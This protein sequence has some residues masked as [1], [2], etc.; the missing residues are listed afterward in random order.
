MKLTLLVLCL[1][2]GLADVAG[3]RP[4]RHRGTFP[5]R[6]AV[7]MRYHQSHSQIERWP[8]GSGDLSITTSYALSDGI[9]YLEAGLDYTPDAS[10][11]DVEDVWTPRLNMA[12]LD[13]VFVAKLGIANSHVNFESSG[14]RWT[15]L[16]YQFHLGV[17]LPVGDRFQVGGGAYYS[18]DSWQELSGFE[19]D[20]LEYGV[21]LGFRF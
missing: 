3:A 16:L 7:G 21:H 17:E 14:G 15:G 11:E 13:G 9:G 1:A 8:Y 4:R 19:F 18:F 2:L 20:E 10:G 12:M 6:A 5:A